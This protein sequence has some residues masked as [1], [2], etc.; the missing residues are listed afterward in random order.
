[1]SLLNVATIARVPFPP[2]SADRSGVHPALTLELSLQISRPWKD[3][4]IQSDKRS[5]L[6]SCT[7][8]GRRTP[9]KPEPRSRPMVI[10]T[11]NF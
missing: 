11:S 2:C 10:D 4:A 5:A 6:G 1:M 9:R 7:G 3:V 8:P